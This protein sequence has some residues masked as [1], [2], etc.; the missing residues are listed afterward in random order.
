MARTIRPHPAGA[1]FPAV[2]AEDESFALLPEGLRDVLPPEAGHSF[3]VVHRLRTRFATYGYHWVEPPLLEFEDSLLAGTGVNMSGDTFRLMDPVSQRMLG[4]RADITVQIARIATTRLAGTARPLRLAYAGNVLRVK[5][6]QFR[7]ER[8]FTQIGAELIGVGEAAADVEAVTMA[9]DALSRL[10]ISRINV[11]LTLP[12]LVP[13]IIAPLDAPAPPVAALMSA[14]DRKDDAAVEATA[15]YLGG[16]GDLI[17]ALL[18]AG[19]KADSALEALGAIDLPDVAR[20][21]ADRLAGITRDLMRARP[22][23]NFTLDFVENRGLEYHS[24]VSFTIFSAGVRGE[25]GLG[26][27][28][29]AGRKRDSRPQEPATGF[30]LYLAPILRA[31]P[32]PAEL[33]AIYLPFGTSQETAASLRAA[34][35][36]AVMALAKEPDNDVAAEARRLECNSIWQ[37]GKI[38]SVETPERLQEGD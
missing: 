24:G 1:R 32:E 20:L 6:K 28:Y 17:L 4:V 2:I 12:T 25:L 26:G 31:L 16:G 5:G 15:A 19:G 29:L 14:L 38:V 37:D 33:E 7:P 35:H 18:R 34:G 36:A 3:D 10:G 11:D 27:R 9:V 13:A 30:T 8:Q 22:A 23:V 21:E